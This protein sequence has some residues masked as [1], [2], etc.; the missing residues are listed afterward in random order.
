MDTYSI[1]WK[2]FRRS[3]RSIYSLYI[4]LTLFIVSLFA[5]I[6]SNDKPIIMSINDTIYYP[7]VIEY[8]EVDF[9]FFSKSFLL[10]T[11]LTYEY[12]R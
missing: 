7:Y 6:I 4:F 1:I 5:E 9:D 8:T 3:K 12:K 11:V 2:N 10:A